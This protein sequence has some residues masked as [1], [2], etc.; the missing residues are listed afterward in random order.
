MLTKLIEK[1]KHQKLIYNNLSEIEQ[2]IILQFID[3]T[4]QK[5]K[6][7]LSTDEVL[8]AIN[9]SKGCN[10]CCSEYLISAIKYS[11]KYGDY[12]F[13]AILEKLDNEDD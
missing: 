2:N 13:R 5:F 7:E 12:K 4:K 9:K 6:V 8:K 10:D 3:E 11:Q 1:S